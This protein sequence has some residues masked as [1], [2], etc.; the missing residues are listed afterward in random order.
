MG[1][2]KEEDSYVHLAFGQCL[3][4]G[5][6]SLGRSPPFSIPFQSGVGEEDNL[7]NRPAPLVFL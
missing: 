1:P 5:M 7:G 6:D 4:C 3:G 2:G